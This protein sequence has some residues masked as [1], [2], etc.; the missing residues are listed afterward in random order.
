[1]DQCNH[2]RQALIGIDNRGER[3]SGCL[4]CNLWS[5]S[6]ETLWIELCAE[7]LVALHE[8]RRAE[9]SKRMPQVHRS[10]S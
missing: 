6:G 9:A 10:S 5:A 4:S 2:C 7:D 1:M 3:L 8:L